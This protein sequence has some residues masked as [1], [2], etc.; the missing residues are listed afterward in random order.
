MLPT[1]IELHIPTKHLVREV[2]DAI[3][4]MNIEPLL[5]QYKGGGT[6]SYHS[7]M[8]LKVLV[9][10]YTQKLYSSQQIAKSLRE[11]IHFMWLSGNNTPDF[12]HNRF[13]SSIMK[14]IIDEKSVCGR[15]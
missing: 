4:K 12:F 13:R 7:K 11:N 2:N 3:D 1:D 14:E 6:S 8:M 10:A 5:R 15:V 9:Y